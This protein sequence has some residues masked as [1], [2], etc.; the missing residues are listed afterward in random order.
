MYYGE[1]MGSIRGRW[2]KKMA[3]SLMELYPEKFGKS[4]ESNKKALDELGLIDDKTVR[5]KVAGLIAGREN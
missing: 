2:I 5:N 3:S 1:P 4:F